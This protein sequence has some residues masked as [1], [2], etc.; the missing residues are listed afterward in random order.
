M[1]I[2]DENLKT[3]I[4]LNKTNALL[5]LGVRMNF[6]PEPLLDTYSINI[7]STDFDCWAI[8]LDD[9]IPYI[10]LNK[11]LIDKHYEVLGEH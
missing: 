4:L 1:K 2:V 5:A 9:D 6:A 7:N 3:F 8:C 11:D 10:M